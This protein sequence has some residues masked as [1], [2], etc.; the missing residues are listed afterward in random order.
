MDKGQG[1]EIIYYSK[2]PKIASP[3]PGTFQA[4]ASTRRTLAEDG[5][6][7]E[8]PA[9]VDLPEAAIT[10]GLLLPKDGSG[11]MM[12]VPMYVEINSGVKQFELRYTAATLLR[13]CRRLRFRFRLS[14][15]GQTPYPATATTY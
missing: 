5:E 14:C 2:L 7:G 11:T 10:G 9:L 15:W 6:P 4:T 13:E 8:L 1:F 3:A 12:A